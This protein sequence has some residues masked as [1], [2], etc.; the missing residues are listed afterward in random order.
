[1]GRPTKIIHEG[2]EIEGEELEFETEKEA[3][4]IYKIE[5]GTTIKMKLIVS[6]IF[7]AKDIIVKETGEPLYVVRHGPVIIPNVPDELKKPIK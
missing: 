7:R 4:N 2:K 1:M 6:N 5:D 3:W